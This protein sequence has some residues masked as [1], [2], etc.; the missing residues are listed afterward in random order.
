MESRSLD[1]LLVFSEPNRLDSS[2]HGYVRYLTN[3]SG[4]VPSFLVVPIEGSQVLMTSQS[5]EQK[6][7]REATWLQDVRAVADFAKEAAEILRDRGAKKVGLIGTDAASLELNKELHSRTA[8][9]EFEDA[10]HILDELRIV[11]SPA[12]IDLI[13]KACELSRIMFESLMDS[14]RKSESVK[15]ALAKMEFEALKEGAEISDS[16]ATGPNADYPRWNPPM[17]LRFDDGYQVTAGSYANYNGYWCQEIRMGAKGKP[18]KTRQEVYKVLLEAQEAAFSSMRPGVLISDVTEEI[19][20]VL[21][22][23]GHKAIIRVGHGIGLEYDERYVSNCFPPPTAPKQV[24]KIQIEKN[25]VF[26]IH[27]SAWSRSEEFSVVGDMCLVTDG[28][29]E[30]L[31]TSPRELFTR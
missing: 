17:N 27:P 25:M 1:S 4:I 28:R 29:P 15:F 23:A 16:Y 2:T 18:S 6:H 22:R 9:V 5:Y 31:T 26:Q 19:F 11:K 14:V 8:G 7:A 30:L 3:W 12:E 21:K 24:P 20:N 10:S 13:K